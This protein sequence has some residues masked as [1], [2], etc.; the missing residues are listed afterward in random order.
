MNN[1]RRIYS[2]YNV[3]YNGLKWAEGSVKYSRNTNDEIVINTELIPYA[4]P[5]TSG[6]L[7]FKKEMEWEYQKIAVTT[8]PG[9]E[10]EMDIFS[11]LL[12]TWIYYGLSSIEDVSVVLR[13]EAHE[14]DLQHGDKLITYT[15]VHEMALFE[16]GEAHPQKTVFRND[17]RHFSGFDMTMTDQEIMELIKATEQ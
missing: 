2:N 11:Q 12:R 17:G 9:I 8:V 14:F 1:Y 4:K 7:N 13:K 6:N 16:G 10:T 5:E 15:I 3:M